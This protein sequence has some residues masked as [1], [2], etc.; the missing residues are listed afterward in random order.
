NLNDGLLA[1]KGISGPDNACE[2]EYGDR[3]VE[4]ALAH[5]RLAPLAIMDAQCAKV[6]F[7]RNFWTSHQRPVPSWLGTF[8]LTYEFHRLKITDVG[9]GIGVTSILLRESS[10]PPEV[11]L[12]SWLDLLLLIRRTRSREIDKASYFF[13][14]SLS[15]GK[16]LTY[17]PE[18]AF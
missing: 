2:N 3:R 8:T 16:Y 12:S 17:S 14:R 18:V 4:D 15:V 6:R 5:L 10:H 13:V 7:C 11:L 9:G 1:P